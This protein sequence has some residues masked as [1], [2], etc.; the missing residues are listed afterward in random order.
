MT[1]TGSTSFSDEL[2]AVS[3]AAA[4]TSAAASIKSTHCTECQLSVS[5]LYCNDEAR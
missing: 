5:S 4:E 1:A 2:N 3:L